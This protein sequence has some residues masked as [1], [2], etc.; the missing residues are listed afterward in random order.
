MREEELA[1]APVGDFNSGEMAIP[2]GSSPATSVN[3]PE[4]ATLPPDEEPPTT[5]L[6]KLFLP[7]V[8]LVR[9]HSEC[10]QKDGDS[11][12]FQVRKNGVAVHAWDEGH[13]VD[14]EGAKILESEPHYP[15]RRV[16]ELS[17]LDKEDQQELESGLWPC[18]KPDFAPIL[19]SHTL[20]E[21]LTFPS[22]LSFSFPPINHFHSA[23]INACLYWPMS[24]LYCA[25][26]SFS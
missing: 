16:L 13:R 26:S 4:P 7:Y 3:R 22:F 24:V 2:R 20:N 25:F 21:H 9:E 11:N 8:R 5:N 15:K 12:C 19:C 14:W 23:I 1:H 18:L 6:P 17:H 10:V